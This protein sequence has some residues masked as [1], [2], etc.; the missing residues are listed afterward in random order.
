MRHFFATLFLANG[1]SMTTLL[2]AL[3]NRPDNSY[4]VH[5]LCE[6]MDVARSTFYNH[7]FRRA[8]RSKYETEHMQLAL[9]V[10]QIFDDSEQRYG[11][12]KIRRVLAASS[13]HVSKKRV[14]AIMQELGLP[15]RKL[16]E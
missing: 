2:E 11:A 3:Y 15:V 10:K 13:T 12:E 4:N 7:I 8:D 6:A 14:S 5:E 9:K 16:S 1:V